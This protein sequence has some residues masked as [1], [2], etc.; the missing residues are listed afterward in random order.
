[1]YGCCASLMSRAL[2]RGSYRLRMK[3][4]GIASGR[5]TRKIG[6]D[7]GDI[8][9]AQAACDGRHQLAA[10]V[11]AC[12]SLP[13][14]EGAGQV[15]GGLPRQIG[16][17]VRHPAAVRSVAADACLDTLGLVALDGQLMAAGQLLGTTRNG[18]SRLRSRK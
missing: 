18:L 6:A 11:P 12:T 3:L 1:M 15:L 2:P 4:G 17:H 16:R 13:S 9:S 8:R 7:R 14:V 5:K 10:I